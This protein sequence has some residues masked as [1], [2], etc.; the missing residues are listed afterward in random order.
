MLFL[1]TRSVKYRPPSTK[2][3]LFERGTAK[4]YDHLVFMWPMTSQELFP[5]LYHRTFVVSGE[6][7]QL[8]DLT[9]PNASNWP[10]KVIRDALSQEAQLCVSI[11]IDGSV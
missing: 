3:S 5:L 1:V 10:R 9:P 7:L 8:V 4:K 11:C 6:D 2:N